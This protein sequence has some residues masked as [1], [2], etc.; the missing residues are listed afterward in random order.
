MILKMTRPLANETNFVHD[1][2]FGDKKKIESIETFGK[3]AEYYKTYC[4]IF[5]LK[6]KKI[7][8]I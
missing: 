3:R 2:L 4:S 7:L 1:D 5:L 8:K 6:Q